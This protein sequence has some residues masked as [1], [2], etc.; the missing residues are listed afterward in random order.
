[1]S[2]DGGAS[3]VW[4]QVEVPCH[5]CGGAPTVAVFSR[6][7]EPQTLNP[8]FCVHRN[9]LKVEVDGEPVDGES[10]P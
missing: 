6:K 2:K 7:P 1:M 9:L 8:G 3:H 10:L 5:N 4:V